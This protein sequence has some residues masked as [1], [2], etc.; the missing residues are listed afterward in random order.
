MSKI[1]KIVASAGAGKT[2]YL[3]QRLEEYIEQGVKPEDIAFISYTNKAV[4]EAKDRAARKFGGNSKR[5]FKYFRTLHSLAFNSIGG[6]VAR[7]M[8]ANVLNNFGDICGYKFNGS[9]SNDGYYT[10]RT[11][12]D[13]LL[14]AYLNGKEM[15]LSLEET[16]DN[17][18]YDI[19]WYGFLD[20]I[21]QYE[22]FKQKYFYVDFNDMITE[23]IRVGVF[24]P[25]KVLML[26]EAQDFSPIQW[27]LI[28]KLIDIS[29]EVWVAGDDKQ[30]IYSF[31]NADVDSF[32]NLEAEHIYLEKSYRVPRKI[33]E[34]AF[35]EAES[36]IENKL[37]CYLK[38]RDDEGCVR[39]VDS[40]EDVTFNTH[41]SYL[42]LARNS[43]TLIPILE[44]LYK[45]GVPANYNNSTNYSD[46]LKQE[47]IDIEEFD[48]QRPKFT[49]EEDFYF[50]SSAKKQ[51]FDILNPNVT[52]STI[53]GAKGAEADCVVLLTNMSRKSYNEQEISADAYYRVLYVALTRAKKELILVNERGRKYKYNFD[54][55]A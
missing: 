47:V 54:R 24:P 40:I 35:R 9:F 38:P 20:F 34:F 50:Y 46:L 32:I 4:D 6:D 25:F 22:A 26:D 48:V 11:D 14:S 8:N 29:E 1:H 33:Q 5:E 12:S 19:D 15:G 2:T 17:S 41:N 37:P 28:H 45:E 13:S 51:G 7:V 39:V 30:A 21:T 42:I 53:H 31:R 23:A 55:L 49:N 52:C 18:D 16:Y 36:K 44:Y 3:M 10:G 27:K 43:Y